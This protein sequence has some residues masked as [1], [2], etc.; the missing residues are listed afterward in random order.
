MQASRGGKEGNNAFAADSEAYQHRYGR[1]D[2]EMFRVL[3]R[4]HPPKEFI[5]HLLHLYPNFENLVSDNV[6]H[7]VQVGDRHIAGYLLELLEKRGGWGFNVL[8]KQALLN[9]DKPF[10]KFRA[11]SV[12]K[13][14]YGNMT[15]TPIH[16]AAINPN[17]KCVLSLFL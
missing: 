12:T 14:P 8:H 11:V 10:D 4:S 9:D 3:L 5:D 1:D 15:I 16:M 2:G 17:P 13:K 7:A 6:W